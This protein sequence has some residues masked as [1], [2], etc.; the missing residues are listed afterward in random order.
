M[1]MRIARLMAKGTGLTLVMAAVFMAG[2]RGA[3]ADG[4]PGA[5]PVTMTFEQPEAK[6]EGNGLSL[7]VRLVSGDGEPITRQPVEF[8]VTTDLFDAR[9][10]ALRSAVTN[11]DGVATVTYTPTWDGDHRI[12]AQFPGNESFRPTEATSV[13]NVSGVPSSYVPPA[14]PLSPLR[15]WATPG[16]VAVVLAVWLVLA[17]VPVRVGWG[18]WRAGRRGGA[19]ISP[20][21]EAEGLPGAT[22]GR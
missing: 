2:A 21:P 5:A 13:L 19:E 4:P 18:V 6:G 22:F 14:E 1:I 3:L 11:A 7:S 15:Q 10:V 20:A 16:A 9:P 8:F 12:T 17:A